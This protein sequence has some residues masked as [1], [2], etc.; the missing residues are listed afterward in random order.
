MVSTINSINQ[1]ITDLYQVVDFSVVEPDELERNY[2]SKGGK[3]EIKSNERAVQ[4]QRELNTLMVVY[5]TLSDIPFTPREPPDPFSGEVV[6]EQTFGDPTEETRVSLFPKEDDNELNP[7]RQG[8]PN[9]MVDKPNNIALRAFPQRPV[10]SRRRTLPL[11]S[12]SLMVK[13][14]LNRKCNSSN[15]SRKP[16]PLGLRQFLLNSQQP[17]NK[18]LKCRCLNLLNPP[19]QV[20]I[21][22]PH[23]RHSRCQPKLNQLTGRPNLF[24]Q[25][26]CKRSCPK[27]TT[28]NLRRRH[29]IMGMVMLIRRKLIGNDSWIM[30]TKA[31][32]MPALAKPNARKAKE[33]KRYFPF[34]LDVMEVCMAYVVNP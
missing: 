22:K 31:M 19:Q 23:L 20:L 21:F 7:F 14:L 3:A 16:L 27:S 4:E 13:N 2:T 5:T 1:P 11:C 17:V 29:K 32:V 25:Q 8:R 9:I 26:I 15:Q 10:N 34:F 33:R 28:G 24:R 18:H 12:R 30:M 6:D